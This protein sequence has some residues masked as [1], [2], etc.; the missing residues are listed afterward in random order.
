MKELDTVK[1]IKQFNNLPIGTKG[2]I[3]HKYNNKHCEVE[4]FDKNND[5][6]AVFTTPID[7]LE[8]IAY[9]KKEL[10]ILK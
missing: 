8:L 9:T 5:T 6:I 4:F 10:N 7:T 1:L 2:V 3:V